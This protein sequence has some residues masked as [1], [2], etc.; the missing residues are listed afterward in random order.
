MNSAAKYTALLMILLAQ[1]GMVTA[2]EKD[3]APK[4]EKLFSGNDAL[5]VRMIAPWDDIEHKE[6]YQGTYPAT[7]EFTDDLGNPNRI[8]MTVE[9]RGITRQKVC[10]FPPIKL[11]FEKDAV[12]GTT[13]RGEKSLKLV[14][15]CNKGSIYE[16]YVTL[17]MLA[18]RMYNLITDFSF[19]VRP[20]T[21]TYVDSGGGKDLGPEL[22]FL[23]EDD[24]GV[25]KRN[26]QENL[27]I[28]KT[29]ASRLDPAQSSNLSL[30]QF[31]ISNLDWAATY[32][33]D[34]KE[35]CHNI[36]LVGRDP[37]ADPIYPVPYDFDSAGLV[38]AKYA[39]P[40]AGLPVGR[41]TQRL[42]RGYCLHNP[43]LP[44][45][46]QRFLDREQAIYDLV[47]N[48]ERLT[49]SSKKKALKFLGQ[50]FEILKSDKE[51]QDDIIE[52]CRR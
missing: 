44:E 33:P 31:M 7:I 1:A 37:N 32:G 19:R 22:A 5:V 46:K 14:T 39:A 17:E 29:K 20:L 9:R 28:P 15:H 51:Y 3:Q 41:T 21:V 34:T 52:Q 25:A 27:D 10:K 26:D 50:F 36:K 13:F 4:P 23:I 30:F 12:K 8:E 6:D 49:N 43:S 45:A 2:Q 11:R 35:C 48:E 40:P 42:W 38:D 16:Q 24:S 18:Y 47:E